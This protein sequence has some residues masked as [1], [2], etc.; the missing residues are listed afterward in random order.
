PAEFWQALHACV[1]SQRSSLPPMLYARPK[2]APAMRR[3]A[4]D[5]DIATHEHI[6]WHTTRAG[7]TRVLLPVVLALLLFVGIGA[8]L[9]TMSPSYVHQVAMS[10]SHAHQPAMPSPTRTL[11]TTSTIVPPAA[12]YP[13]LATLYVGRLHSLLTGVTTGMTLSVQQSNQVIKGDFVED[14]IHTPFTGVLDTSKHVLI[15]VIE[16]AGPLFFEG[17]VRSDGNLVGNY[18][19]VDPVGQCA[20]D[21]GIWSIGPAK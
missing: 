4:I 11:H 7:K 9:H 6:R 10:P 5:A 19:R 15:T 13:T 2:R 3:R 21:Y 16:H 1:T 17:Q 18:C 8:W 20:G 12:A 14:R